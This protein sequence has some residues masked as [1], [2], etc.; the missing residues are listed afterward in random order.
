MKWRE[1]TKIA[2]TL[3]LLRQFFDEILTVTDFYVKM[4]L[5]C[6]IMKD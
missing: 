4:K 1:Q 2:L 6:K 5:F 3:D